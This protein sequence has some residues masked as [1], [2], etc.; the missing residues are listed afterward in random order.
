MSSGSKTLMSHRHVEVI[1]GRLV[2]DEHF[3]GEFRRAARRVLDNLDA[4]G[5]TLTAAE[6]AALIDTPSASWTAMAASLDPRLQRASLRREDSDD[7]A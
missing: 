2:S 3:R 4:A 6:R 1:I 5:L 7:H